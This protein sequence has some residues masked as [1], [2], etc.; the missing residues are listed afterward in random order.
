MCMS[1]E[2]QSIDRCSLKYTVDLAIVLDEVWLENR[3]SI[4]DTII[5]LRKVLADKKT[6]YTFGNGGSASTA[7]H[8]AC[9]LAKTTGKPFRTVSLTDN[10]SLVTAWAN[11][12]EYADIFKSQLADKLSLGDMVV[13]I[14]GSGNSQN[15]IRAVKYA[16]EHNAITIGLTGFDGGQLGKIADINVNVPSRNM[17]HIEDCHLALC[18]LI[19]TI[20]KGN[21]EGNNG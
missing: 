2:D 7:S 14:S 15:V 16:K 17:Q 19:T 13:A 11:D 8:L 5:A 1:I 10:I 18:H 3:D 9:D 12:A 21:G 20:L 4:R 6:V